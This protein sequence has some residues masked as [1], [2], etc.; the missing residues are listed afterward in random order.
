L[1]NTRDHEAQNRQRDERNLKL[2]RD[3]G[4]CEKIQTCTDA[5]CSKL[6]EATG[7]D[8]SDFLAIIA[9]LEDIR[10]KINLPDVNL[11]GALIERQLTPR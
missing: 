3:L 1:S 10:N 2:S 5:S 4:P 8:I 9:A 7:N 11:N 6:N